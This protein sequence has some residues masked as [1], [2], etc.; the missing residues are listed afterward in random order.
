MGSQAPPC[1]LHNGLILLSP[2]W[3]GQHASLG[4]PTLPWAQEMPAGPKRASIVQLKGCPRSQGLDLTHW[5]T[6]SKSPLPSKPTWPS[7][8][9]T[10][11][12]S[13]S[14]S[15]QRA[16]YFLVPHLSPPPRKGSLLVRAVTA[17]FVA[18]HLW[19]TY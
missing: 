5:G 4:L 3:P 8:T 19:S 17:H 16:R 14:L 1:A 12:A 2:A 15:P 6:V 9:L 13:L 11:L 10:V 18:L 7:R